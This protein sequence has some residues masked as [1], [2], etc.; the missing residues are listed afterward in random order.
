[1]RELFRIKIASKRQAT[2]PQRLLEILGITEGDEIQIEVSDGQV[3][4]VHACKAV[5]TAL[6]SEELLAK[7]ERREA[8]L[9]IRSSAIK[10]AGLEKFVGTAEQKP[11]STEE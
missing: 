1:M 3:R 7:L 8:Q 11:V 2:V 6:L 5:P 9:Q 10:N 4:G